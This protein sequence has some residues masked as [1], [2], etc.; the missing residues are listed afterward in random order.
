MNFFHFYFGIYIH[1]NQQQQD[2][3]VDDDDDGEQNY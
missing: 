1:I 3:E 2:D